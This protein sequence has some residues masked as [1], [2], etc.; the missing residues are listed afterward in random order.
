MTEGTDAT[1]EGTGAR[2]AVIASST[3]LKGYLH[4]ANGLPWDYTNSRDRSSQR[5][6][7]AGHGPRDAV[8]PGAG[9]AADSAS[10]RSLSPRR[11]VPYRR[12][13]V[14]AMAWSTVS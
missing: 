11:R 10:S 8:V 6:N 5:P 3:N 4:L 12:P 9:E 13:F 7:E 2:T 14:A 1:T